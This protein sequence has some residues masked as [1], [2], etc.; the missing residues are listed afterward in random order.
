MFSRR[1]I[2]AATDVLERENHAYI[3]RFLLQHRLEN[4]IG[5]G[6][7]RDRATALATYLL[8]NPETLNEDGQNLTDVVVENLVERA[9]TIF[10]R[11]NSFELGRLQAELPESH[12]SLERDGFTVEEGALRRTL[13]Q[14]L[15]LPEAVDDVH[16]LTQRYGFRTS[17]GHLDQAIAAHARGEWAGANAQLRAFSES[18]FDEIALAMDERRG[19]VPPPGEERRRWLSQII[20]PFYGPELNEWTGRGTGFF[21][22]FYRRLHPQGAH[23]GLS[24]EEDS[25][26]RLHLVL[27]VARQLL[28][29]L[30]SRL[31]SMAP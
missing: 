28:R 25:T 3:D 17:E 29:R 26:F 18:L 27:L 23:P 22:A 2:L 4:A 31:P 30:Q 12:R 15:N 21:E 16:L 8:E 24:D 5:G 1:T 11:Y 20:P 7:V 10:T 6:Y 14:T 13:P 19:H 9:I